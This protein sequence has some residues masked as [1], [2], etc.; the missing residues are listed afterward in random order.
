MLKEMLKEILNEADSRRDVITY[1]GGYYTSRDIVLS[2]MQQYDLYTERIESYTQQKIADKKNKRILKEL[3]KYD[4][5]S[6]SVDGYKYNP[7]KIRS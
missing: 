2:L 5:K 4:I 7:I 6:F 1:K 3:D